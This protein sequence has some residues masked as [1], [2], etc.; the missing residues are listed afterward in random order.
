MSRLRPALGLW[1]VVSVACGPAEGPAGAPGREAEGPAPGQSAPDPASDEGDRGAAG[2]PAPISRGA[3]VLYFPSAQDEGLV[4]QESEIFETVSP[5]DRAK[6]ILSDLISG[7]PTEDALPSLPP[8]TRLRQ[9]YVLESGV[10][11][12]DFSEALASGLGGGSSQEILAIYSIVDSLALNI[13]EIRRVGILIEGRPIRTLNGHLDLRR[14]LPPDRG[15]IREQA[16]EPEGGEPS[17][18]PGGRRIV[19]ADLPGTA[20]AE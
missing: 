19:R 14:P 10:A 17:S 4:P 18:E 9:V 16:Q 2:E 6:Q 13:P 7:P 11:W 1:L 12:A 20:G 8:G 5:A 3:V 15:L